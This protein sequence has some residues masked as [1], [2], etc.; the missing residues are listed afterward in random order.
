MQAPSHRQGTTLVLAPRLSDSYSQILTEQ[1]GET[2]SRASLLTVSFDGP[3]RV[4]RQI[5][6]QLPTM[7][8]RVGI[9]S[10]NEMTRSTTASRGWNDGPLAVRAVADAANLTELGIEFT[11]FVADWEASESDR[12]AVGFDSLTALLQYVETGRAYQFVHVVTNRLTAANADGVF[13][14]DPNAHDERTVASFV[15]LFD[16]VVSVSETGEQSVRERPGLVDADAV[17]PPTMSPQ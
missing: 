5:R 7:P 9:L 3:D 14:M 12:L 4:L 2:P 11:E 8:S 15:G 13:H 6:Q 10:V 1:L 16:R 17:N